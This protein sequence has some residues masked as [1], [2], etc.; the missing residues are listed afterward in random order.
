MDIILKNALM[1]H[2]EVVEG[3]LV[4]QREALR[5]VIFEL[6]NTQDAQERRRTNSTIH[7]FFRSNAALVLMG[8]TVF[9]VSLPLILAD[10][11]FI[12][13][14]PSPEEWASFEAAVAS[15]RPQPS[16]SPQKRGAQQCSSSG[17]INLL[18]AG[19]VIPAAA[20]VDP[21]A[22]MDPADAVDAVVPAAAIVPANAEDPADADPYT[23]KTHAE[24]VVISAF[25]T[26]AIQ[27]IKSGNVMFPSTATIST[28]ASAAASA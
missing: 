19:A 10:L 5:N 2:A 25:L 27:E 4:M 24:L 13:A 20:A 18:P 11:G 26:Q 1:F 28:M 23:G 14:V 17:E 16:P 3:K 12:G 15:T 6:H 22:A 8:N 7:N 21:G 9:A